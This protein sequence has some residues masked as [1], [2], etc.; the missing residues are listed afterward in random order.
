MASTLPLTFATDDLLPLTRW[1][2]LFYGWLFRKKKNRYVF[3]V[4]QKRCGYRGDIARYFMLKRHGVRVGKYS[5]GYA[6]LCTPENRVA[7]IGAFCSVADNVQVSAGNHPIDTISSHP[8]YCAKAFGL[9][10]LPEVPQHLYGPSNNPVVIGHDV[11]IGRD[12]T[13]LTGVT[14]GTGAVIAAGAVVTKDVPP[15]AIVGGVPAKVIRYRFDDKTIKKLL[16]SQWWLWPDKKLQKHLP[17]FF[18]AQDFIKTLK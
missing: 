18:K 7:A 12:V 9:S 3:A 13:I 16:A 15:Y 2:K 1:Q 17:H 14:I 4:S 8:F 6:S 5:Y 11:W 10:N